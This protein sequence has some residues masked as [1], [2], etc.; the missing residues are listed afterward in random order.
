MNTVIDQI[1]QD[2]GCDEQLA[3]LAYDLVMNGWKYD[4]HVVDPNGLILSPDFDAEDP[5]IVHLLIE[6]PGTEIYGEMP[7]G[8]PV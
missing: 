2:T 8:T 7:D 6:K 3:R 4:S 1:V 5:T